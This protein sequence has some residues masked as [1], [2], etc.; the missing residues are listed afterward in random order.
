MMKIGQVSS[1]MMAEAA[2]GS[3]ADAH[4]SFEPVLECA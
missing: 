3:E 4:R 1:L 2:A